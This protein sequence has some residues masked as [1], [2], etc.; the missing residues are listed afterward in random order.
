MERPTCY[1]KWESEY[2]DANF[3]WDLI[4]VI[5]YESTTETFLQSLQFKIIHRYFPCNY[6]LHAWNIVEDSKCTSCNIVDTLSHYFAE[7]QVVKG[8]WE[9]VRDGFCVFSN[10]SLTLLRIL[11][12]VSLNKSTSPFTRTFGSSCSD[13]CLD[14]FLPSN[15]AFACNNLPFVLFWD[16]S[17]FLNHQISV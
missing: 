6:R 1:Y 9:S 16:H 7:H 12:I 11:S 13:N 17:G 2:F 14:L 4:N 8:F 3:D 5:P 15:K 10:L